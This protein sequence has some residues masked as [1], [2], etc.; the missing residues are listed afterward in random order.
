MSPLVRRAPGR[1]QVKAAAGG[2]SRRAQA[3][4][5]R[6]QAAAGR[7]A[8]AGATLHASLFLACRALRRKTAQHCGTRRALLYQTRSRAQPPTGGHFP[9]TTLIFAVASVRRPDTQT[10]TLRL[11]LTS[12]LTARTLSHS[13][14][15]T[16]V[17]IHARRHRPTTA[18]AH[19][20][21][22]VRT[23]RV[24]RHPSP[25]SCVLAPRPRMRSRRYVLALC[26]ALTTLR[27]LAQCGA[28]VCHWC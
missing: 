5:L 17:Q 24:T 13:H 1:S 2:H 23:Q 22:C 21:T 26:A 28:S 6:P 3:P 15:L 8:P 27:A 16:A 25:L 10:H 4:A 20:Q 7:R 9:Y 14:S 11:P 12:Q 19:Q 18:R